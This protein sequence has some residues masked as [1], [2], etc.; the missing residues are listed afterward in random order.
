MTHLGE[1]REIAR[2]I[3]IKHLM[4]TEAATR[5]LTD[6]IVEA[7]VKASSDGM[8]GPIGCICPP[9]A[10]KECDRFDC[11]RKGIKISVTGNLDCR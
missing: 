2:R 3:A 6:A 9:G 7:L 5:P 8:N 11:P 1:L 10:N 4:G